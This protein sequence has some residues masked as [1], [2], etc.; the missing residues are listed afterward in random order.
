MVPDSASMIWVRITIY[1]AYLITIGAYLRLKRAPWNLY[2]WCFVASTVVLI[3]SFMD[4]SS[5]TAPMESAFGDVILWL[6]PV[7]IFGVFCYRLRSLATFLLFTGG[8]ASMI[9][10]LYLRIFLRD[11]GF[12]QGSLNT[13][14]D[15]GFVVSY[16]LL[17]SSAIQGFR[18][19]FSQRRGES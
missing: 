11:K 4:I 13:F 14:S 1:V 10:P 6:L 19:Y 8:L 12:S 5:V 9:V 3:F 7:A 15:V 2:V 17:L 18:A 16:I